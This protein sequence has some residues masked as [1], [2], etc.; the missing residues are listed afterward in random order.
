MEL[1]ITVSRARTKKPSG[2]QNFKARTF[3]HVVEDM[4]AHFEAEVAFGD[5]KRGKLSIFF[6]IFSK[7]KLRNFCINKE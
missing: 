5:G 2:Q 1:E 7:H 3:F 6:Q 4:S